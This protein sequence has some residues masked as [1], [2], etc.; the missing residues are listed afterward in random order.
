MDFMKIINRA[1]V[2]FSKTKTVY[3][4]DRNIISIIKDANVGKTI[5]D[6]NK[7][8]ILSHLYKIDSINSIITPMFSLFEGQ[9]GRIEY[10]NE[11]IDT[12]DKEL[13]VLKN[14]FK[15]AKV[16]DSFISNFELFEQAK[17]S[18]EYK[19]NVEDKI[20][21]LEDINDYLYQPLSSDRKS[22]AIEKILHIQGEKYGACFDKLNPVVVASLCCV[23]GNDICKKILKPKKEVEKTNYYNAVLDFQH[24]TFFTMLVGQIEGKYSKQHNANIHCKFLSGDKFLNEFFNWY[25]VNESSSFLGNGEFKINAKLNDKG[26]RNIPIELKDF[27]GIDISSVDDQN[28]S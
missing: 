24:F 17:V 8:D 16:D 1:I 3:F 26:I 15:K 23:Y 11:V 12:V 19:K 14:F 9:Y 21:F 7:K 28:N 6:Q 10:D 22:N 2:K 13:N 20:S 4:L 5:D 27:F 18:I 25:K